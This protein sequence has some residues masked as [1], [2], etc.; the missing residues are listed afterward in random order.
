[1]NAELEQLREAVKTKDEEIQQLL[2]RVEQLQLSNNHG[3][4]LGNTGMHIS[5]IERASITNC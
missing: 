3:T 5:S 2:R 4:A 1:M